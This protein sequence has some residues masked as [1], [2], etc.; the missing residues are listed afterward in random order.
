MLGSRALE[1]GPLNIPVWLIAA[2]G[3]Y[4]C[5]LIAQRLFARNDRPRLALAT[6]LIT[7]AAVI[8]LVVW[9]IMPLVTRFRDIADVP[10]RL[11]Y[12]PGGT[13][14]IV[15]GAILAV[16]YVVLSVLRRKRRGDDAAA[17]LG[18]LLI[19]GGIVTICI[20]APVAVVWAIPSGPDVTLPAVTL[21]ALGELE[22][23]HVFGATSDGKPTVLVF[24]ATWCGPCTAQMPEIQ[25]FFDA[26]PDDIRLV[27]VNLIGTEPGVDAVRSYLADGGF[28]FPVAL[29]QG[30]ILRSRLDVAATPTMLVFDSGGRERARRTG[31]V[32]AAWIERRVL[33]LLQ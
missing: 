15:A 21:P 32:T 26:H 31:A 8:T 16:V 23:P 20:V 10:S 17:D 33:P 22:A 12:Y 6:D 9:K 4:V 14:G 25:R 18:R 24:W 19:A 13:A 5:A 28:S 1:I 11:L 7:S 27:T 3:G 30:D 2:A 29:D